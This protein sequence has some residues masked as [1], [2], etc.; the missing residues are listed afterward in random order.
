LSLT[1]RVFFYKQIIVPKEL[2]VSAA[3]ASHLP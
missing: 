2:M 3:R 1:S